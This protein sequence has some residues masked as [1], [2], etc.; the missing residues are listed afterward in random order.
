MERLVG[1]MST[2]RWRGL[3]RP[4]SDR[5]HAR[6]DGH[7]LASAVGE[8]RDRDELS[9]ECLE[10][11][12]LGQVRRLPQMRDELGQHAAPV[13]QVRRTA[14]CGRWAVTAAR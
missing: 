11:E 12:L 9:T 8:V 1:V 10:V 13:A 2:P 5:P 3:P 7:A 6:E 14:P 4:G